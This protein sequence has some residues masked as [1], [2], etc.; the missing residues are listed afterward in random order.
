[1]RSNPFAT[2]FIAPGGLP[3]AF[4]DGSTSQRLSNEFLGLPSKMASIIGPHGTGKS[5]LLKSILPAIESA[6]QFHAIR[7]LRFSSNGLANRELKRDAKQWKRNDFVVLDG[8]EQLGTW[9]KWRTI[10]RA[11]RMNLAMLVTSHAPVSG[12]HVLWQTAMTESL[13]H[14]VIAELLQNYDAAVITQLLES[15]EWRE[16]RQRHG[17]NLRE[18]LFDM[19]D[20][21]QQNGTVAGS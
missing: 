15:K 17:D 9:T 5:T 4:H 13:A 7:H 19:Y 16:S 8:Y 20:W 12:F 1:V 18:T 21:W 2:R 10:F 6:G 11:K 3:F 14:A